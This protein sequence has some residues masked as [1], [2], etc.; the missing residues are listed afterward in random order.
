MEQLTVCLGDR[1]EPI[2]TLR[3][4]HVGNRW[5]STFEYSRSWLDDARRFPLEPS[6]LLT[7]GRQQPPAKPTAGP[8]HSVFSDAAPD[9]WGLAVIARLIRHQTGKFNPHELSPLAYFAFVSD[10]F[11][12]GALRFRGDDGSLLSAATGP[13]AIPSSFRLDTLLDAAQ[14]LE[15]EGETAEQISILLGRSTSL[16]GIRPKCSITGENGDLHV[17]KFPSTKDAL[18]VTRGEALALA[19]GK[20]AGLT[21]SDF[22]LHKVGDAPAILVKRFDRTPQGQRLH[23]ASAL[24]MLDLTRD[25][26]GSYCEI[27]GAI[28]RHGSQV[29]DDLHEIFRRMVFN[30]LIRNTDNHLGNETMI[31]AGRGKWRLSPAYDINPYPTGPHMMA[32]W[33]SPESGQA[34]SIDA[35]IDA[36]GHFDLLE[37]DARRIVGGIAAVVKNWRQ[38]ALSPEVG[39]TGRDADL[40][41][42]AFEHDPMRDA[43]RLIGTTSPSGAGRVVERRGYLGRR[44]KSYPGANPC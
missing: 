44:H 31:Y 4:S 39:M 10:E 5:V 19:L 12:F 7:H 21:V 13:A 36:A 6:L 1:P 32:T 38:I 14:A 17:A 16:V 22:S 28:R 35:C 25:E 42:P 18:P 30:I 40:Y 8:L 37:P 11:R 2:G 3:C 33:I 20:A 26:V 34:P 27:A 23:C 41:A 24:T 29:R 9:G 15:A 43:A